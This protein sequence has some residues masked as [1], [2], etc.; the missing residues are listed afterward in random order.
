MRFIRRLFT[1][2]A[3][4][5]VAPILAA[6]P[7]LAIAF[8]A[9]IAGSPA[10]VPFTETFFGVLMAAVPVGVIAGLPLHAVL[11]VA[12]LRGRLI[13]ALAGVALTLA[14]AVYL[15]LEEEPSLDALR[16]T[17]LAHSPL[18][19]ATCVAYGVLAGVIFQRR[20]RSSNLA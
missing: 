18:Q 10:Y 6:T 9:Y 19:W 16:D 8:A 20:S 3:A 5:C 11:A 7:L 15:A 17:Y 12:R 14:V 2:L 1:L 13:Y 4:A